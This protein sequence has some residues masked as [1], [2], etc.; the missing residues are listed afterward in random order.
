[1]PQNKVRGACMFRKMLELFL[2]PF[3]WLKAFCYQ[4]CVL[5]RKVTG[6]PIP[7]GSTQ[8]GG[9]N[10]KPPFAFISGK[11][12]VNQGKKRHSSCVWIFKERVTQGRVSHECMTAPPAKSHYRSHCD[13]GWDT[14]RLQIINITKQKC[15]SSNQYAQNQRTS[16]YGNPS[17]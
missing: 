14:L 11:K 4:V 2:L 7:W 13:F 12:V 3:W 10:L 8:Q 17:Y 1:M 5:H 6:F 15:K 9:H 16:L